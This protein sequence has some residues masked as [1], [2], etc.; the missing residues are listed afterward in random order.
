MSIDGAGCNFLSEED[1]PN[2]IW[3]QKSLYQG[4]LLSSRRKRRIKRPV[5]Q[6]H[7]LTSLS[8]FFQKAYIFLYC[9]YLINFCNSGGLIFNF[10]IKK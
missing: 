2:L 7:F 1:R 4:K 9:L 3:S 5:D 8:N 6:E 10:F